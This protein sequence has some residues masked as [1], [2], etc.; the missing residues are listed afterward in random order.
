MNFFDTAN[1]Y[2]NGASESIVGRALK[3]V[4]QSI[5]LATKVYGQMGPGVNDRGL[6][7]VHTMRAH[8]ERTAVASGSASTFMSAL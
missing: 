3:G 1:V 2:G 6:S 8:R 4:R 7:R 5:V